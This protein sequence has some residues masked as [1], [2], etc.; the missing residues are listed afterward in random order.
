MIV[1]GLVVAFV[2]LSQLS[3]REM[4]GAPILGLRL[5][6]EGSQLVVAWVQPAGYAWNAG[7]R[8]GD[9]VVAVDGRPVPPAVD[10]EAAARASSIDVRSR[11]GRAIGATTEDAAER[12]QRRLFSFF[13][14][15]G[16]FVVLGGTVFVLSRD[17]VAARV[18]L[19]LSAA[20]AAALIASLA[21]PYGATWALAVVYVAVLS[22]G[23]GTLL[24]ALVFPMDL[25]R[26]RG[27]RLCIGL[28]LGATGCLV[29][30]YAWAVLGD[31]DAYDTVQ[32]L[33]F[34]LVVLDL[35]GA[36][37]VMAAGLRGRAPGRT[38]SQREAGLVV[39]GVIVSLAPFC[40][41]SLAPYLL[42]FGYLVPPDLAILGLIF[43]P[44][45][46]GGAI[47][48][49]QFP[50]IERVVR[51]GLVALLVWMLLLAA[52]SLALSALFRLV[53][54]SVTLAVGTLGW[55]VLAVAAIAG[56]FPPIER[57]L[58]RRIEMALFG[59]AYDYADTLYRLSSDLSSFM[60]HGAIADYV[61]ARL[62]HSIGV[63]WVAIVLPGEDAPAV[64]AWGEPPAGIGPALLEAVDGPGG[65]GH[66][67]RLV[68]LEQG[69]HRL[70]VLAIGPKRYDAELSATD[71]MLIATLVPV[72]ATA[73][74][75]AVLADRLGLQ[76]AFL[77]QRERELA[78]L[79]GQLMTAQEGERRRIALDLHD[80]PLQRAILLARAIGNVADD[81]R[82]RGWR[83]AAEEIVSSLQAI[84]SGLRP[85]ALDDFGLAA[86]LEWLV[87]DIRA[88]SDLRVTLAVT[89]EDERAL[90][91]LEP[92]LETSLF[93]VAQEAL[94][95]CLKHASATRVAIT[96]ACDG[97]RLWLDI[98]DDGS[99]PTEARDDDRR[100]LRLG[101]VGMRERLRPWDGTVRLEQV[102]TGG[103]RVAV[104]VPFGGKR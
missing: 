91:R 103:T 34:G 81:P 61:T 21:S 3:L 50:G 70:G 52:Y 51:R 71:V 63:S 25:R 48:R 86:S 93:R 6:A 27:G 36:G 20:A 60:D 42:G 1:S 73:L 29:A 26:G 53:E 96:L 101:M 65:T 15:A 83:G 99:P 17:V 57:R 47:L 11:D 49:G 97:T 44:L 89:S 16:G 102:P 14:L 18:V 80:D 82:A 13:L 100:S 66:D 22:F 56:T 90:P 74:H 28:C 76:V 46:L 30:L 98:E 95:N 35:L 78:A 88:R 19:G 67:V 104:D 9:V 54:P 38:T 59:E 8:P 32:R 7:V 62:G 55:M 33:A 69:G 68:P 5:R 45:S 75:N 87:D 31:P 92:E 79:G 41:A 23:A 58:R 40:L 12:S 64:H 72:I 94:N 24:L 85:R 10:A 84:C 4:A 2:V 43:L 39:L 37:L 77:A